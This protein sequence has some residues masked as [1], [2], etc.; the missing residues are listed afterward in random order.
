M[1]NDFAKD[2]SNNTPEFVCMGERFVGGCNYVLTIHCLHGCTL[3]SG[4][5]E[6]GSVDRLSV[7]PVSQGVSGLLWHRSG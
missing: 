1:I 4:A 7:V 3:P 2:A 6:L 5:V